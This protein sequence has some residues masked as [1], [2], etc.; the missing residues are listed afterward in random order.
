MVAL[1]EQEDVQI[2]SVC[3][4]W[5]ILFFF[6]FFSFIF[7]DE[8]SF[9]ICCASGALEQRLAIGVTFGIDL[10]VCVI[11]LH[12]LPRVWLRCFV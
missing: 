10:F 1:L 11:L 12:L 3:L 9:S 8:R 2:F 7:C 6:G 4:S 5:K